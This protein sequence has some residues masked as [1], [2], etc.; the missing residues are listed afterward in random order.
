[1]IVD[2]FDNIMKY[3]SLLPNLEKGMEAVRH[4]TAV[5]VGRYEFDGGYFMVQ[6]GRTR[7][8]SEGTYEAHRKYIDV[9]ILMDGSEEMAW[10]DIHKLK[11]VIPYQ[12]EKDAERLGGEHEHVIKVTKGMFYAV[13]PWDAHHPAAHIDEI[14]NY[15]KVVL[16]L[17]IEEELSREE[18]G[19]S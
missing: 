12:P 17:R 9:Q 3:K 13:F 2:R 4:M 1:M 10:E 15:L 6:K 14:Q 11:T 7:S 8:M 5:E 18:I 16:K 19:S